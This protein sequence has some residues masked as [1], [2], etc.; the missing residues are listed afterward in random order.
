MAEDVLDL[1]VVGGGING[2]G[3][4]AEAQER[5]LNVGLFEA[6][7][8]AGATSSAS[9]KLIHGGLRYLENY[10]F[11]MVA[12]ALAE[13]EVLLR[14]A[15]HIARSM[16]FQ[17]PHKSQLR[18][19]WLIRLGL[20]LYD[21]L[22]GRQLLEASKSVQFTAESGLKPHLIRG[23]EYSDG[24]VDDARL[25]LL[26]VKHAQNLGAEVRNYCR[27]ENVT[28][29][30][31]Q[32][33]ITLTD[34]RTQQVFQRRC[35]A[36]INATG[37]W[38][39]QFLRQTLVQPKA[40]SLRLVKGSHIV[41]PRLYQGE[42]AYLLQNSD[43]R[44]VFVI[45]YLESYALIGT[46]D[47]DFDGEPQNAAITSE[48]IAYLL[49][50]VNSHFQTQTTPEDIVWQYSGVRPLLADASASAQSTTRDYR[51]IR[52]IEGAP[53]LSVYGGKLTTYRKLAEEAIT[54]L[55]SVFTRLAPSISKQ[56][57]LPG[58]EG[59]DYFAMTTHLA[60]KFAFIDERTRRRYLQL[61]GADVNQLLNGVETLDDLGQCFAKGVYQREIDY[62]INEEFAFTVEDIL[63]RRTKLGITLTKAEI[64]TLSFYL[65]TSA[66]SANGHKG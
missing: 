23:F 15:P 43:K 39:A 41:V 42:H 16:R 24:W 55:K 40:E 37:P 64:A 11:K 51:L 58:G 14:K 29:Q 60:T 8:F 19:F 35:R 9:S 25:V 5:G 66:S 4:A 52:E 56:T 45:P 12:A 32:W 26:N 47:V 20:F 57:V 28:Q 34:Q 38:A 46:T 53:L 65:Q 13:R 61:Y 22:A 1:I 27:V 54:M 44:V 63:W 2:A 6:R 21:S 62:L 50:V 59:Y 33:V 3:I 18:P 30:N 49:N 36:L 7:D 17:L 31:Q 10:E 48:E